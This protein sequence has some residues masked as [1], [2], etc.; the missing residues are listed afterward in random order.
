MEGKVVPP[1][2]PTFGHST[3]YVYP[4][5]SPRV[6]VVPILSCI[7]GFPVLVLL[8]ICGL[9]YRARRARTAAKKAHAVEPSIMELSSGPSI[10]AG[11]CSNGKG[12]RPKKKR[13]H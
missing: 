2:L 9:R 4:T 3:V 12:P 10:L 6:V 11:R 7:F 1:T 5:I 8:V 13:K